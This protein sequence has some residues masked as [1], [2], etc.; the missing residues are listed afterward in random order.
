MFQCRHRNIFCF[1]GIYLVLSIKSCSAGYNNQSTVVYIIYRAKNSQEI[2]Q[3]ADDSSD[4]DQNTVVNRP[5]SGKLC[6]S[7]ILTSQCERLT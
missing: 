1:V 3:G 5:I 4:Q 6:Q 2:T 7:T